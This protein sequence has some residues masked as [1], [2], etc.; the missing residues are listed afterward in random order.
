MPVAGVAGVCV[1]SDNITSTSVYIYVLYIGKCIIY[2]VA[3]VS[4]IDTITGVLCRI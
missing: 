2:G 4:R 3:T 1:C